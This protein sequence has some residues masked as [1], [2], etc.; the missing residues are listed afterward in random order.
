[1]LVPAIAV[2]TSGMK[3]W[4]QFVRHPQCQCLVMSQALA[5]YNKKPTVTSREIQTSVRLILPGELAKHAVSEVRPCAA[6]LFL[7]FCCNPFSALVWLGCLS[8]VMYFAYEP[9]VLG[10]HGRAAGMWRMVSSAGNDSH[11]FAGHEG[12]HQ[13]HVNIGGLAHGSCEHCLL[14]DIR[15]CL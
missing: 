15:C 13:V 10:A 9:P 14:L 3:P 12:C 7:S 6:V 5:R 11:A 2:K 8:A 4:T 1:M